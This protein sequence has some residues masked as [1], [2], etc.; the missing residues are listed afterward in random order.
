[1]K[2]ADEDSNRNSRVR[3]TVRNGHAQG[4][5][6]DGECGDEEESGKSAENADEDVITID[7]GA[8]AYLHIGGSDGKV[9]EAHCQDSEEKGKVTKQTDCP[10][11]PDEPV[12]S[13]NQET[14]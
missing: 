1:M 13:R 10:D 14:Y 4:K 11:W 9:D 12:N 8:V 7:G 5:Q 6:Q 3:V 2:Q